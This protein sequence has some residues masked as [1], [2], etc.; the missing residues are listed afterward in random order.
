MTDQATT[1]PERLDHERARALYERAYALLNEHDLGNIPEIFTEDVEFHDDAWP[2]AIHG[3][4]DMERFLRALWTATPDLRF[5]VIEAYVAG[6]GARTA[7]HLRT[8]G[9][10]TGDFDPPG[11]APTG[12]PVTTEV[13]GFHEWEGERVKRA[14]LILNMQDVGVQVGALPPPG[15]AG[16]KLGVRMQRMKARAMRRRAGRG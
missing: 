9:T 12:G 5:E 4:A 11:F 16:E 13:G 8:T 1:A 15:S 3:H 6:D 14:R 2:E 10:S 7:V